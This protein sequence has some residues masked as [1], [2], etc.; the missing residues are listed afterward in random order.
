ME[1][2][3]EVI[4]ERHDWLDKEA[5]YYRGK[6]SLKIVGVQISKSLLFL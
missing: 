4:E 2:S 1:V 5:L 6:T 3:W